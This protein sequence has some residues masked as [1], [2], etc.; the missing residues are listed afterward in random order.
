MGGITEDGGR[1]TEDRRCL[2]DEYSKKIKSSLKQLNL[3]KLPG[4]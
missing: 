2:E 1:K 3:P 4:F